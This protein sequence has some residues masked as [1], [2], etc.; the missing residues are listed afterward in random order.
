MLSVASYHILYTFKIL[1]VKVNFCICY[2]YG[3]LFLQSSYPAAISP[4]TCQSM[5][6]CGK[7]FYVEVMIYFLIALV[8]RI[9]RINDGVVFFFS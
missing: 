2:G 8:S 6:C 4:L 1:P 5:C 9:A 3:V 7:L